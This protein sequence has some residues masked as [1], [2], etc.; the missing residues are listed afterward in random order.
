VVSLD[1][2][3]TS[4]IFGNGQEKLLTKTFDLDDRIAVLLA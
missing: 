1:N 3:L 4:G 2:R